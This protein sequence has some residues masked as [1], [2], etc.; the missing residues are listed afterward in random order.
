MY[1]PPNDTVLADNTIAYVIAR[2][3]C[4]SAGMALLD[5]IQLTPFYGDPSLG[6]E[7][8]QSVLSF[9][10]TIIGIGTVASAYDMLADGQ[11][12]SFPVIAHERVRDESKTSTIQ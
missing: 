12:K 5:A 9:P 4:P 10:P 7:Y 11:S 8:D 1:S 2:A 3:Y 6:D